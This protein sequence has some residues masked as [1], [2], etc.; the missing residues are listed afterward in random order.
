MTNLRR[1]FH[2]RRQCQLEYLANK[3]QLTN[4]KNIHQGKKNSGYSTSTFNTPK[5][6]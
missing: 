3:N 1:I 4:Y 2:M 5:L 6:L